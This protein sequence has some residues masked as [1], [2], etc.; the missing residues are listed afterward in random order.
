MTVVLIMTSL[1][2][3]CGV[4]LVWWARRPGR[5]TTSRVAGVGMGALVASVAAIVLSVSVWAQ[6]ATDTSQLAPAIVWGDSS[7]GDQ[8]RFPSRPFEPAADPVVFTPVDGPPIDT[9]FADPS[10]GSFGDTLESNGTT[11][12]IVLHG[13]DL[14]Y[15]RYFNGSNHDAV[16]TSFSVAKSF[17]ATLVGIAIDGGLIAGL[18]DPIT[19]YIPELSQRDTRFG[20]ITLLHLITMS[21]GLAF[22][23]GS[24]P[25]AD[26]AN[27]YYASDLRSAALTKTS[28]ERPPGEEFNFNDWNVILLGFVLER[29]TGM[30]VSD[31][32]QASLW[33]PMGAEAEGSWSL[34]SEASGFE[35]MFVGINGRAIDFA[36]LGWLYLHD[37]HNGAAQVVSSDFVAQATRNDVD[38]DPASQYQYLWWLDEQ[39]PGTFFANG[40]HCRQIYV[41]PGAEL[42]I[43]R[44]GSRCGD[45]DWIDLMGELADWLEP[46]LG[47]P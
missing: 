4:A 1:L 17:T 8:F 16:Q 28:V 36:K 22:R 25:W 11:A 14:L 24:S 12:F 38:T 23:E 34:D 10:G 46:Q 15:E 45:V 40:D 3:A 18:D 35:K 7:F 42:V 27:T 41:D 32:M 13:N 37:G 20:D 44:H 30:S 21:S 5:A 2:I 33:Q 39:R 31:Y 43:V 26:P 29:A 19:K 6:T 47:E 9:V